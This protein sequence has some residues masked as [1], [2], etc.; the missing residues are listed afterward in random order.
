MN[1]TS[2]QRWIY[3]AGS[4]L[5]DA[6]RVLAKELEN[7]EIPEDEYIHDYSNCTIE[8]S[9]N[10]DSEEELPYRVGICISWKPA[11]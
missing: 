8:C 7:Y 9:Y 4:S 10:E 11:K 2:I 6:L 3:V 1:Y 5:P